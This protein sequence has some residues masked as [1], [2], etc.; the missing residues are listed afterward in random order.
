MITQIT[1][2][3]YESK[4]NIYYHKRHNNEYKIKYKQ[5]HLLGFKHFV[6]FKLGN[7]FTRFI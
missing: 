5:I 7:H 3:E 1:F 4:R 2:I 6:E